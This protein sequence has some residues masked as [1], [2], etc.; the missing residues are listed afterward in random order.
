[1]SITTTS[2]PP[3]ASWWQQLGR[4]GWLQHTAPGEAERDKLDVR[5]LALM[6]ETLARH[7]GLADFAFAMQGLGAGPISLFGDAG[8]ARGM[9]AED[10]RRQG[11]RRFRPDRTGVRLRRRQYHDQ[12]RA[13]TAMVMSSTARRRWISNGGIADLYVVFARTGEA[14]GARGLS[15]F[16]VEGSNPGLVDRRTHR[17]D[18]AASAGA[19][20]ASITAACRPTP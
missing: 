17:G 2:M 7:A 5:T 15:A 10:A 3:A 8:A 19:A 9:A 13:A 20:C 6:R 14:P 4:D 18:R 16:I 1:M 11:D 12:P